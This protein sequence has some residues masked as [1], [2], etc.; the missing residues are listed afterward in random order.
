ML[1]EEALILLATVGASGLLVLGVV[2]LVWPARPRRPGARRG[3]EASTSAIVTRR[4]EAA[5]TLAAPPE[6]SARDATALTE[7]VAPA[8]VEAS[9]VDAP[10]ETAPPASDDPLLTTTESDPISDEPP[11]ADDAPRARPVAPMGAPPRGSGEVR[12][13]VLPI[14]T[15]RTMYEEGRFAEVVSLGSAALEVHAGLAAVSHR[16]YEAAA[17]LDLVGLAKHALGD[18]PGACAAFEAAILG[19]D[20]AARPSHIR[21][22]VTAVRVL[23]APDVAWTSDTTRVRELRA[24]LEALDHALTAA[25][26]NDDALAARA[27]VQDALSAAADEPTRDARMDGSAAAGPDLAGTSIDERNAP[28]A[29]RDRLRDERAAASSAEIG[30]L[31]AHAIRSVQ[32][33]N[34]AEALAALARAEHLAEALP[35]DAVTDERREEFERRLWWGYSKVGLRRIETESFEGALDPLFRAL[36]FGSADDDRAA[37]T[38]GALVRALEGVV[39]AGVPEILRLG[40]RDA[41]AARQAL[42]RLSEILRTASEHGVRSDELEDLFAALRDVQP[43]LSA[44]GT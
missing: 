28:P 17:L 22:L 11:V 5:K 12:P 9:T 38:R 21:H 30:Q 20:P 37:E 32:E 36:R 26:D 6:M 35:S 18:H 40:A 43:R 4:L 41:R 42:E 7:P 25:P 16:P 27:D 29:W 33:G 34:D 8:P 2:E 44:A 1:T 19:A 3:C 31:T 15:C 10:L 39:E 24:C 13:Q 23:C 14:D